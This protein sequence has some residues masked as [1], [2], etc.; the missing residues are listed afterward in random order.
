VKNSTEKEK[1]FTNYKVVY[2][3]RR[4]VG[5]SISP[6]SG[7]IVRAPFR[8]SWNSIDNIIRQKTDWINKHLADYSSL[9]RLNHGLKYIDGEIHYYRGKEN[10]LRIIE[11][12]RNY[13]RHYENIIEIGL[14]R[15]YDPKSIKL[16]LDLWYKR[17]ALYNFGIV[18]NDILLKYR[19][20]DFHPTGFTVR[21]MKSRWGSC[22]SKGKIT[23]SSD[24]IKMPEIYPEYVILHELCHLIHHNHSNEYYRLLSEVFPDWRKVRKEMKRY[25][26]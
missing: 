13:I 24:L 3:R 15:L 22:T 20:Y 6:E 1:H 8:T 5:I 10:F 26:R 21:V 16:L 17:E 7:V 14:N 2:S 23:I 19:E 25:V 4:S 9:I 11:S 18:L 12:G